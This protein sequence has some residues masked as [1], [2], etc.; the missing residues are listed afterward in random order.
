MLTFARRW[1][2]VPRKFEAAENWARGLSKYDVKGPLGVA[3][4]EDYLICISG[5]TS[6]NM[7]K[8]TD[9]K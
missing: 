7:T 4:D 5:R 6:A 1:S 8:K 2:Q 3:V 9:D